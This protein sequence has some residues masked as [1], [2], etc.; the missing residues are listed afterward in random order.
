MT[1]KQLQYVV[2][3]AEAGS[4]TEA[5]GKLFIEQPSH[6]AAIHELENEFGITLFT[7]S[8]KGIELTPEGDEFFELMQ[9]PTE[10][11]MTPLIYTNKFIRDNI[12]PYIR[13]EASWDDCYKK[14][15]NAL[16]LYKDE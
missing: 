6:T 3:T 7:R 1:L 2:T 10:V 13:G 4:I 9:S 14:F 12:V 8:G 11:F 16:E 15:L 5:A